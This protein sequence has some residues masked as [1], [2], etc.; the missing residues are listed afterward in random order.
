[1]CPVTNGA[2]YVCGSFGAAKLPGVGNLRFWSLVPSSAN[3]GTVM[4][5]T[6]AA[7]PQYN[8]FFSAVEAPD[9][10]CLNAFHSSV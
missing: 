3:Q 5:Y 8:A 2:H 9:V 4:S 1:M 10:M 7:V 6:R